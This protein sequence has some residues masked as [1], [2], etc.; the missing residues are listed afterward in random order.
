[1]LQVAISFLL[2]SLSHSLIL[3]GIGINYTRGNTWHTIAI[4]NGMRV[5]S[6]LTMGIVVEGSKYSF[7]ALFVCWQWQ[8]FCLIIPLPPPLILL[9]INSLFAK[10]SYVL[11]SVSQES[12]SGL[13]HHTH[14]LWI[15]IIRFFCCVASDSL[16]ITRPIHFNAMDFTFSAQLSFEKSQNFYE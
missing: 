16:H 12:P 9:Y 6:S 4:H 2:P 11:H 7:C 3:N 14:V 1:M 13:H 5:V 10:K 15:K 8:I